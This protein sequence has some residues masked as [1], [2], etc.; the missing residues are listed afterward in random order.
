MIDL[1]LMARCVE[2][3]GSVVR[4]V[5]AEVGGSA[6]REVGAAMLVWPEGQAGTI[7]GGAL[8]FQA[9]ASARKLLTGGRPFSV[10]R[11]AL[12][13][14]LGQCCGGAVTLVSEVFDADRLHDLK[15]QTGYLRR[16]EGT[17][18]APLAL[19]GKLRMARNSGKLPATELSDGWLI[20]PLQSAKTSLWIWGAGHVG[21]AIIQTLAPLPEYKITWVDTARERFPEDLPQD[22]TAVPAAEPTALVAHAP[23]NA[24]HLILT[25][26]HALDLELCHQLLRHGFDFIGLIGSHTKWA[27]FQRRLAALGHGSAQIARITCPI[28]TPRLGKHPQAIA[29]GVAMQLMERNKQQ[30][31]QKDRTA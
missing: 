6:P 14:K 9:A 22:V 1:A 29:I 10:S 30:L 12:G 7:G 5:I 21:R 13:P 16:V 17:Q 20:E 2:A 27:R 31:A 4:V 26:S 23:A 15:D 24:Q 3:H 11:Q 18:D 28:G 19:C 25:Y 8:E